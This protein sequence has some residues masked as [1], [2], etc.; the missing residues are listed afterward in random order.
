M[1]THTPSEVK[2]LQE[3]ALE[4]LWVYLREPSDMAEKGDPT[5]FVSGKGVH[6]TDA[7]GNKNFTLQLDRGPASTSGMLIIGLSRS[8]WGATALPYSLAAMGAASCMLNVS[9]DLQLGVATDASGKVVLKAGI[10]NNPALTALP[11][12]VQ[13]AMF[14]AGANA[15]GLTTTKGL[16]LIFR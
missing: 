14:E 4:H 16:E 10:P 11:V 1:T 15:A 3:S 5:I 2:S 13:W 9:L 12:Y 8:R 7:L 6:V